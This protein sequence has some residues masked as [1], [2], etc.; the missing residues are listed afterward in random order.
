M[1]TPTWQE[2]LSPQARW[3]LLVDLESTCSDLKKPIPGEAVI[4]KGDGEVIEIGVVIIDLKQQVRPRGFR[5][6][7]RPIGNPILTSY[8]TTLTK[9]TQPQVDAAPSFPQASAALAE[10]L[11]PLNDLEG[12]WAWAS[13]GQSDLDVL[14]ATAAR[15]GITHPL[16]AHRHH[17]LKGAFAAM[18]GGEEGIGP[19]MERLAV[20]SH[21]K[22][23]RALSDACN[24]A[25]F[26]PVMRRY[27][28]A[29][30]AAADCW[31]L[32]RA[33]EWMREN[34]PELGGH[35]PAILMHNDDELAQ[36]LA[37]IEP[38]PAMEFAP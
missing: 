21:G 36:V 34:S 2:V 9:I 20:K 26:Y 22:P 37:V 5:T 30:A 18:R 35:R 15:Y 19:A 3:L 28:I 12:G 33:R 10:F 27:S 23:H 4:G 17:N 25:R 1:T 24:L 6:F 13:W 8:C 7:V 16:P 31:G 38:A 32:D 11:A 14:D 29:Q